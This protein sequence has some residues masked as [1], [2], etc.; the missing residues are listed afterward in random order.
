[1]NQYALLLNPG[2]NRVYYKASQQL[3]A[4]EFSIV[5]QT[6]DC[7]PFE[8]QGKLL[9]G[10]Y[11]LVFSAQGELS[12]KDLEKIARLSFV[13][14]LYQVEG[15]LLR[16]LLVPQVDLTGINIGSL[17]KYTGKTNEL[18]TRMMIN[19]AVS[20]CAMPEPE[21]VMLL[22]P[23]AGK[24]TTLFEGLTMGFDC[25]GIEIGD[26][27]AAEGYHYLKKYLEIEHIKHTTNLQKQSGANKSFTAKHYAVDLA[28][29][30]EDF[31]NHREQHWE[32]VSGNSI[33]ADQFFGKNKFHVLVGDLPYG[34]QHGN[35]TAEKQTSLTRSPKELVQA[36]L[37]AWKNVLKP[38]GVLAL[39]WNTFVFP[40]EQFATL[41][42]QAG[43]QVLL[44]GPYDQFAHRVDNSIM[45]DVIV[46]RKPKPGSEPGRTV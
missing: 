12:Q 31:K 14:A 27:A 16:P 43:F 21:R 29:N 4:V 17:L 15:E 11:Y 33:Y 1:M 5:A 39:A 25:C 26:K 30:K 13:F 7:A 34:V 40:K 6:M 2:H 44:E 8:V 37:P 20:S 46:A 3:S 32:I 45:R 35:V 22:D 38:G 18:F 41:L 19:V 9:A 28:K 23:I 10:V 24:G 36:C 42:E